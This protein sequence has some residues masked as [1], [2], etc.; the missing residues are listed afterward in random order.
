MLDGTNQ[1]SNLP[2]V[3]DPFE[4]KTNSGQFVLQSPNGSIDSEDNRQQVQLG[5]N[6]TEQR[7]RHFRRLAFA[8]IVSRVCAR[9]ASPQILC[10]DFVCAL[11]CRLFARINGS[12][13]AR[14]CD[15]DV[16]R[17]RGILKQL[18]MNWFRFWES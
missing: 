11:S 8:G 15:A 9:D 3:I 7:L 5:G 14:G 17:E 1:T 13:V 16:G 18:T 4:S 10:I 6:L 12:A 2:K